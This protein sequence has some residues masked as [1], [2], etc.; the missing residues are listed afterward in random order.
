MGPDSTTGPPGLSVERR[1]ET[2]RLAKDFQARAYEEVLPII[3]GCPAA[4]A[5][6][7]PGD[8]AWAE[9]QLKQAKGVAA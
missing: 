1:Y 7:A 4:T 6:T 2:N 5:A 9:F 8:V 3:R